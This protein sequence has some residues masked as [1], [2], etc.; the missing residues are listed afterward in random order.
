MSVITSN[1]KY[2]TNK[3]RDFIRETSLNEKFEFLI[4]QV[5]KSTG[6]VFPSRLKKLMSL[7]L[8]FRRGLAYSEIKNNLHRNCLKIVL[9]LL[10]Y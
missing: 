5:Q 1:I 6:K 9:I 7:F 2:L 8:S 4:F 10:C 3:M